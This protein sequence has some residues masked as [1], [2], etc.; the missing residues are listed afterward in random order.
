MFTYMAENI[1]TSIEFAREL[2]V[3]IIEVL[4]TVFPQTHVFEAAEWFIVRFDPV[5]R[6]EW[7]Q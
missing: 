3:R 4:E 5:R 2:I 7:H 1:V 6:A